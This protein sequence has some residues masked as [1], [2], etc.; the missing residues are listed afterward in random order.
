MPKEVLITLSIIAG[1]IFILYFLLFILVLIFVLTFRKIMKQHRKSL[2]ILMN[3]KREN[4]I[5]ILEIF[6]G[7]N[8]DINPLIIEKLKQI[9]IAKFMTPEDP[10]TKEVMELLSSVRDQ[11]FLLHEQHAVL[12]ENKD[13]LKAKA[14]IL[15]IDK[16]Y[17]TKVAM[18]NADVLG[19]N[20]WIK[21]LPT[22]FIFTIFK[23]KEKA[24]I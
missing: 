17:R 6:M 21:F 12:N 16:V 7:L 11:T 8:I 15:E 13:Y 18:Y 24:L 3:I 2:M 23:C 5:K 20:Y 14:N 4:V 9:D 1:S 19:Y 22:R 10:E